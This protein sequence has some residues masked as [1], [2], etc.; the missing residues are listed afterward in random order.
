MSSSDLVQKYISFTM[1]QEEQ[2][3][4]EKELVGR[5]GLQLFEG[6]ARM[7]LGELIHDVDQEDAHYKVDGEGVYFHLPFYWDGLDCEIMSGPWGR[8]WSIRPH[9]GAWLRIAVPDMDSLP[10]TEQL[11]LARDIPN[12]GNGEYNEVALPVDEVVL[13]KFLL[14][15]G[16]KVEKYRQRREQEEKNRKAREVV[17]FYNGQCDGFLDCKDVSGVQKYL[18]DCIARMPEETLRW[19]AAATR[20]II[21][22][23]AAAEKVTKKEEASALYLSEEKRLSDEG[24]AMFRPFVVYK[25]KFT[26]FPADN[27]GIAFSIA[28]VKSPNPSV[29]GWFDLIERGRV[30]KIR[31]GFVIAI[32]EVLI[33]DVGQADVEFV[34]EHRVLN[35]E[36]VA[37]L[38]WAGFVTPEGFGA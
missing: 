4:A 31:F 34:C 19:R 20:T 18:A 37:G 11:R 3:S 35:S 8:K 15:V 38:A 9:A 2:V 36:K 6:N 29:D 32:E 30:S 27:S 25:V 16:E 13:G 21:R 1:R 5:A 22:L 28:F 17:D 26:L 14:E 7:W 12:Q 10:H 33:G 23:T 24:A